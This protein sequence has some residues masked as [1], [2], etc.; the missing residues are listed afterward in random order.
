[1]EEWTIGFD[2]E[3]SLPTVMHRRIE[4]PIGLQFQ[5]RKREARRQHAT[6][7]IQLP[8]KDELCM[9]YY[10]LARFF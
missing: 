6:T 1:M 9:E 7:E 10:G 2:D 3:P 8:P 4:K 5:K